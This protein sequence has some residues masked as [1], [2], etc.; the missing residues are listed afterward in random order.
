MESVVGQ[1]VVGLQPSGRSEPTTT[2][3]SFSPYLL[4]PYS[5]SRAPGFQG[6]EEVIALIVHEDESGEVLYVNLPYGLHTELGILDTLDALDA[7]L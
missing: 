3:L 5:L 4:S 6:L 7:R 2:Y 1:S